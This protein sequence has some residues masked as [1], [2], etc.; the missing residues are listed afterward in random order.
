MAESEQIPGVLD[1]T[2]VQGDDATFQF[3]A[4]VNYSGYTFIST[5]HELHGGE[6][7]CQT[8]LS[9]GTSTSTVQV[10]FPASVTSALSV[11]SDEG[12]HNWKLVYTDT[13]SLTRTWVK[14]AFTVLTKI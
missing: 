10:T 14:G 11:T 8:V 9:A 13:S 3:S 6:V 12:S 2:L 1:I 5:I 7:T 4:D